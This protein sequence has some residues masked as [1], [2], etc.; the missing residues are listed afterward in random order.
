[1]A[2]LKTIQCYNMINNCD[3]R[4]CVAERERMGTGEEQRRHT[5]QQASHLFVTL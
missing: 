4:T 2:V 3:L 5:E 1:M